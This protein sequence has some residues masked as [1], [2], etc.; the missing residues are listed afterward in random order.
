[1]LNCPLDESFRRLKRPSPLYVP[2]M[3]TRGI[4]ASI[5]T[6]IFLGEMLDL[7]DEKKSLIIIKF[8]HFFKKKWII[9]FIEFCVLDTLNF[10]SAQSVN[11]G[12]LNE[13]IGLKNAT[14]FEVND[15]VVEYKRVQSRDV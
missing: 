5:S 12:S 14:S 10:S 2:S 4:T 8:W 7:E 1:M 11:A 9:F 13:T 6:S 15:G 3:N